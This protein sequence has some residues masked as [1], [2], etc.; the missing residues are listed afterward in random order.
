MEKQKEKQSYLG[1]FQIPKT[2]LGMLSRF[3]LIL[4]SNMQDKHHLFL[5]KK[6]DKYL[7]AKELAWT[8][9]QRLSGKDVIW[10]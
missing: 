2:V 9:T 7:K 4:I 1:I 8:L 10:I 5:I 6:R 3:P